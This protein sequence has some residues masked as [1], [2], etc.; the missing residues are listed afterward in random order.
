MVQ[1]KKKKKKIHHDDKHKIL[2][3]RT[4]PT[5]RIAEINQR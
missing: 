1:K 5:L 2:V 4:L 3:E